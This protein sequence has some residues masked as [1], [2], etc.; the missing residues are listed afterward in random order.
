MI[1]PHCSRSAMD[2][3]SGM[4]SICSP[5]GRS[6]PA[7]RSSRPTSSRSEADSQWEMMYFDSA[8][9]PSEAGILQ[10]RRVQRARS[11]QLALEQIETRYLGERAVIRLNA[12]PRQ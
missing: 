1:A 11:R 10:V 5:E 6:R 12:G 8:G 7:S 4:M 3:N 2:S 9:A